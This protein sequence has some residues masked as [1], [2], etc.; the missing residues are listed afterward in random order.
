MKKY[1][2]VGAS[3]GIGK[4]LTLKLLVGGNKVWGVAR[5]EKPIINAGQNFF[6]TAMDINIKDSWKKLSRS[7]K[8]RKYFP[9]VVIM[10]AAVYGT[11]LPFQIDLATTRKIME[12]NFFAILEGVN[13]LLP[14][15]KKGS[16]VIVISSISS[17][18]GSGQEG[19]GYPASKAAISIAFESLQQ[20]YQS[21]ILFKTV[22]LGPVRTGMSPF[23]KHTFLSISEDKTVSII[24]RAINSNNIFIY[25]PH[26]L[27]FILR[28]AKLFS[29]KI[30][31]KLLNVIDLQHKQSLS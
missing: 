3:S 13:V 20:K 5:R 16:Q 15:F 31:F 14:L 28:C 25:S 8:A 24:L 7:L 21:K 4:A 17:Q 18:K 27:F 9:D 10:C 30:Y 26:I 29:Q 23:T 19:I 1:L 12:T 11:D 2:V 22:F 6:Y